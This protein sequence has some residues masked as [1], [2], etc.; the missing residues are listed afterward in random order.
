[1]VDKIN[2]YVTRS[3]DISKSGSRP[4]DQKGQSAGELSVKPEKSGADA[5]SLTDTATRLKQI[6]VR[7]SDVPEI[8]RARVE[9]LRQQIQSGQYKIDVGSLADKLIQVEKD[10][11][12]A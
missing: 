1:M 8:N 9:D 7:L 5:V 2:T 12:R 4:V 11:S 10:L 6:E 3:V